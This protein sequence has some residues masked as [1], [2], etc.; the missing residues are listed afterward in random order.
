MSD[1]TPEQLDEYHCRV[2][3]DYYDRGIQNNLFQ[4]YWHKKRFKILPE[5][6]S[7]V[8][9][10]VLDLG[11]HSGLL[12]AKIAGQLKGSVMGLD[13]S[14]LAIRYAS[15]KYPQLDFRVADIQKGIPFSDYSFE[16]VTAFDVLEHI[17]NLEYVVS[18]IKRVLK[19]QGVLLMGIPNENL[20]FRT[21]WYFWTKTRGKVW[22]E[23]HVHKFSDENLKQF[24]NSQGFKSIF[25]K[26]IHLGMYWIIK[27]QKV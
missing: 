10:K 8:G 11:C 9:S 6:L 13:I 18:E 22:Q 14:E 26:K 16:A 25:D 24:F 2:P 23:L 17:S 19:P 4:W 15:R 12:T 21:I 1:L 27:Y 3:A 5:I 7:D 20:L